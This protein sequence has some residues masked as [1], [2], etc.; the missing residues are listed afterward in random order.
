[1]TASR[2]LSIVLGFGV[3]LLMFGAA[4]GQAG[5]SLKPDA[6][7][8]PPAP[9][10]P[11]PDAPKSAR[12][13]KPDR[14]A[15]PASAGPAERVQVGPGP[16]GSEQAMKSGALEAQAAKPAAKDDDPR[17]VEERKD[18]PDAADR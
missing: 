1:M 15:Y 17:G 14:A 12:P 9:A 18:E 6:H 11:K 13:A 8:P 2:N 10:A 3:A 5:E 7:K 16:A 4:Y